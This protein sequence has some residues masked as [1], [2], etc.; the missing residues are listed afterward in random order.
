V[1]TATLEDLDVTALRGHF[2]SVNGVPW[3]DLLLHTKVLTRDETGTPRPSLAAM[4]AFGKTL[5]EHA[6]FATIEAAAYRDVDKSSGRLTHAE[7]IAGPAASQIEGALEFIRYCTGRDG[8]TPYP[9]DALEEAIRNAVQHRDYGRVGSKI[10][11]LLFVDRLEL[12]SP[13]RPPNTVTLQSLPYRVYKRNQLL[14]SFL[15][16]G[17]SNGGRQ[18]HGVGRLLAACEAHTGRLPE[19]R[20]QGDDLLL[21]VWPKPRP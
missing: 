20:L 4:L 17:N 21:M 15:T 8:A 13:G 18:A 1:R 5:Q 12:S 14:A 10:R 11:M 19:Y 9:L 7:K 16:A 3:P 6:P 2:H